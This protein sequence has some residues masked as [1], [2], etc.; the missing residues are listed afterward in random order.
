MSGKHPS[1]IGAGAGVG[2]TNS[3]EI[4][5]GS[6]LKC[7]PRATESVVYLSTRPSLWLPLAYLAGSPT[8]QSHLSHW[9]LCPRRP[10]SSCWP[11]ERV[12]MESPAP[13]PNVPGRGGS[14]CQLSCPFCVTPTPGS[15]ASEPSDP[16]LWRL[17]DRKN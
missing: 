7:E 1:F 5:L 9:P 3:R 12:A 15:P 14:C 13:T 4:T 6:M 10:D 2:F 11:G 16:A 17:P 8:M